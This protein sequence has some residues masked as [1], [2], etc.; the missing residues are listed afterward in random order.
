[1]SENEVFD[2]KLA[3]LEALL[4]VELD[5]IWDRFGYSDEAL[6]L[7]AKEYERRLHELNGAFERDRARQHDYVTTDKWETKNDAEQEAREAALLRVDEKF[8]EYVKRYE[9][10]Q[11]EVD[12]LLAAQ[13]G[14]AD[15]AKR[16]VED[17]GRKSNRN[18]GMASLALGII[19][20]ISSVLPE[21]IK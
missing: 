7:Q 5:R 10:R 6:R 17:Q 16:A 1:M 19:V 3:G 21:L 9:A 20:F 4:D 8:T 2:A 15:Q 18:L 14:A 12:L 13:A 11:R